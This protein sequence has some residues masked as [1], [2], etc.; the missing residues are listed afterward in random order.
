MQLWFIVIQTL[1][2]SAL[3]GLD[4]WLTK[5]PTAIFYFSTTFL[6][7]VYY[8]NVVD[9]FL[10]FLIAVLYSV[11]KKIFLKT[12]IVHF[13]ELKLREENLIKQSN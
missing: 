2:K 8:S 13:N 4:V 12:V 10:R 11:G 5:S 6:I 9:F 7:S 1:G 3:G